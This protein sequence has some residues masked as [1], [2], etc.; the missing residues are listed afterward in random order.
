[1]AVVRRRKIGNSHYYYLEHTFKIG[2]KVEKKE[3]YLGKSVPKDIERIKKLF[4]SEV[5]KEKWYEKF[6]VIK[7]NFGEE[8][9]RLPK[10][11]Q[12]KY[13]EHFMIKFTYDTNRMEGGTLTYK[14][15]ALLLH[16]KITPKN[17]PVEDIKES[18]NHKK[19]FYEMLG[20]KK[21][22]N[23]R[24]ILEWH[25]K[26][27]FDTKPNI[28]GRIR[29]YQVGVTGSK[30]EF[31]FPAELNA[32][33]R[34]FFR[35]Y[36]K[37]KDKLH[38][39]ELATLVHLKFVSIHPFGDGNGRIS[40]LIMNFVLKKHGYPMLSISYSNR[41]SYYN[42][43]ERSQIRKEEQIFVNHVF[44]RYLKDYK[45]YIMPTLKT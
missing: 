5:Y 40:R 14:D 35:W 28:A 30:V 45:K 22:L 16:D 26:L 44:K 25:R 34:D 18:E 27:F 15:T 24:I 21:D 2:K 33:L 9:N 42:A 4:L 41:S 17:R 39:V 8:F 7:K 3:K 1:M 31:P 43:L 11:V 36:E 12:E 13:R 38:P 6:E 23:L 32:V 29:N 19:V 20:Y 37:E 10:E